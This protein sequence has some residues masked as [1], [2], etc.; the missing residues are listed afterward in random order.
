MPEGRLRNR[1][2]LR[3]LVV[4]ALAFLG[5]C[6][7]AGPRVL[8]PSRDNHYSH[9][10]QGWLEGRLHH[11]G[12]PPGWC[13]PEQRR[14]KRCR[15]HGFDDW[16]RVWTLTLR[17]GTS[18]RAYPCKTEA[19]AQ[20]ERGIEG[21]LV[22]GRERSLREIPRRDILHRE[23]TW[24]ISFP[25][26]PALAML[27]AVAL[28]GTQARDVLITCLLAA[29]IPVV[30]LRLFD[31]ERGLGGGA[32]LRGSE[33]L[34]AVAAWTFAS[35][36]A[37]V[38]AHGRVWFTAQI[39]AAL[40][41]SLYISMAWRCRR[42]ALAG[43]ALAMAVACRPHLALAL[44]LFV[45]EWWRETEGRARVLAALRFAA[46]ILVI[47][48]L[49]MAFNWARFED[50][51]EFGHRFLEIRWQRRMQE[52]GM[53]STAYLGRNL[54]CAFSLLPVWSHGPGPW[55]GAMLGLSPSS[56]LVPRVSMH[57]SSVLL[58]APWLLCL[59]LPR[60]R[61]GKGDAAASEATPDEHEGELLAS[62]RWGLWLSA[63]AVALPSLL[64]QN[65]GQLQ[66]S[67]RFALDWLPFLLVAL[68]FGGGAGVGAKGPA[69]RRWLFPALVLVAMAWQ[70]HGAWWFDRAPG[71]LFVT[72]PPLWPFEAELQK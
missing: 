48:G 45:V 25:P 53:F 46:P 6:A 67:Y 19:C 39:A 24:F 27:P 51:F 70:L 12:K 65:S 56:A 68:V 20:L 31:R 11:D 7:L 22:L 42:P 30:L 60:R 32:R 37:F 28:R 49:L 4:F 69:W 59:A 16:A 35:P 57:G 55:P 14:A 62:Q 23:E 26:G 63:A 8:E 3:A 9:M 47:G 5:L 18:V 29:L 17:D 64:Y 40:C 15:H 38:G 54:R 34:W 21:W 10:A 2:L 71:L 41:L 61:A 72:D 66:F 13:G 43:L 1:E 58:G 36:A 50:P 33:H 44:P 52:Q